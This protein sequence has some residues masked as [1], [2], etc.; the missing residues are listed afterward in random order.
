MKRSDL[1]ALILI[2]A[3]AAA[4]MVIFIFFRSR[5]AISADNPP[6][7]M[8]NTP[9]NLYNEGYACEDEDGTVYF[10]NPYDGGRL[11]SMKNDM[12]S[13][14][15]LST[16]SVYYINV[17]GKRIYYCLITGDSDAGV[18]I[19]LHFKGLYSS[20]K[21]GK[22]AVSLVDEN[23]FKTSLVGNYLYTQAYST[24]E[25]Q[26]L[27]KIKID[28]SENTVI[29]DFQIDPCG[30]A[31]G[32]IYHPSTSNLSLCKMDAATGSDQMISQ[33]K[34]WQPIMDGGNIYFISPADDYKIAALGSD[35]SSVVL[36][37]E[38]ADC[39]NVLNGVIY[40]NVIN[41]EQ[42]CL[43][44]RNADGSTDRIYEGSTTNI[45]MTST[46]TYFRGYGTDVPVYVTP[47]AGPVNVQPFSAA[48]EAALKY[49]SEEK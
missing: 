46:Y 15:R 16:S 13:I 11:Y 42:P 5:N 32:A 8:G 22:N 43:M 48:Q 41:T 3:L 23:T 40:Y 18:G 14:K 27:L 2:A 19:A 30:I 24:Q 12:S 47:T 25:A 4:S 10:A 38:S 33:T 39:Y 9:G 49:I 20:D 26:R 28:K 21:N 37:E 34:V 1:R 44:R 17:Y 29:E 7:A 36:T 45:Q 35:G 6:D 31:P